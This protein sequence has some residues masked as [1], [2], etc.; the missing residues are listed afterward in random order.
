MTVPDREKPLRILLTNNALAGR[1]GSE[2]VVRDLAIALLR[3]GHLP[4]CYSTVLGD[5]AAELQQATVPVISDLA[6]LDDPPDIIHGHHHLE[7]MTAAL[8]F[9][10]TPVIYVCNGWLPW[11]EYP[12]PLG[13]DCHYVAVDDLCRK[14]LLTSGLRATD[15]IST[16]YNFVDLDRFKPRA[17]LPKRPKRAL[18]FSN[19]QAEVHPEIRKGCIR[20][21][22][23]R[24]DVIG[25]DSGAI[26][27]EPENVLP[28]YDIVFAKGRAAIEA[29]ATGCSVIV[30]DYSKM[31]PLVRSSNK[32]QL[33]ALNFGVRTLQRPLDGNAIAAELA[34]YDPNDALATSNWIREVASLE[35]AVGNYL[36]LYRTR[37]NTKQTSAGDPRLVS[38]YLRWLS[39]TF[40]AR[41]L[42]L[43]D[44]Y[45]QQ[46]LELARVASG[47][48]A[49]TGT[50]NDQIVVLQQELE[51][52]KSSRSWR[53]I[54]TYGRLRQRFRKL[55]SRQ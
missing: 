23:E 41:Q 39:P 25:R 31:G 10:S 12:P 19:N 2:L 27:K 45:H 55:I 9:A 35:A 8:W 44:R 49:G 51:L 1:A 14:R 34:F 11:E 37:L 48:K 28:G 38:R 30:S 33:R 22:I 13:P 36:E 18:V 6:D 26:A 16:I 4:I 32:V 15:R 50:Q 5:V 17:S 46:Q 40:K 21:G 29:L 24:I 20:V 52:I 7:T 53:G 3:Q 54:Q 47:A 43:S 42:E